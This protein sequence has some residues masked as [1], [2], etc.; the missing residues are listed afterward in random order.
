MKPKLHLVTGHDGKLHRMTL[1]RSNGT[2][3]GQFSNVT[4]KMSGSK[5]SFIRQR[6]QRVAH[7]A[8]QRML[9]LNDPFKAIAERVYGVIG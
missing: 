8:R 2:G 7:E 6:A 1:L 3:I 5:L 4:R 9:I